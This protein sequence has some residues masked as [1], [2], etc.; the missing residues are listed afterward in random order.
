MKGVSKNI[1]SETYVVRCGAER[2]HDNYSSVNA[3]QCIF[4]FQDFVLQFKVV[5]VIICVFI[6]TFDTENK[7]EDGRR[8]ILKRKSKV[9]SVYRARVVYEN[10]RHFHYSIHSQAV[11]MMT[12]TGCLLNNIIRLVGVHARA[13]HTIHQL[14]A[15]D[16][17]HGFASVVF[18][19]KKNASM[20]KYMQHR[21]SQRTKARRKRIS[22]FLYFI[23]ILNG[24]F[25]F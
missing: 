24:F 3:L 10:W 13:K 23:H 2:P 15:F 25:L 8:E 1:F 22:I 14:G 7:N 17:C 11:Y 6:F 16:L 5:S 19:T 20:F 21:Q 12:E 18:T 4:I 9:K